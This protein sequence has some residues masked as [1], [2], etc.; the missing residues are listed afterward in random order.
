MGGAGGEGGPPLNTNTLNTAAA[1]GG[2][3]STTMIPSP[4][5]FFQSSP[6]VTEDPFSQLASPQS[7]S[8]SAPSGPSS[9]PETLQTPAPSNLPSLSP[10]LPQPPPASAQLFMPPPQAGPLPSSAIKRPTYAP[11]PYLNLPGG[12]PAPAPTP[13]SSLNIAGLPP[14]PEPKTIQDRSPFPAPSPAVIPPSQSA[15]SL[16]MAGSEGVTAHWFY[17]LQGEQEVWRPFSVEDST[18]LEASSSR[19]DSTK[20]IPVDGTRYDAYIEKR[21]KVPVYWPGRELP[22]RRCSWFHRRDPEGRWVPY[23]ESQAEQLE[24]EY[25]A[26]RQSGRWQCK[27][28]FDSGEWVMLHSPGV[29]MHFPTSS[30]SHGALDDW[31]QVQ[32]QSDPAS[33]PQVVH[34]GLEGLPDIPDGESLEVDHVFFVVHGIGAA[35]DM[36]FRPLEEVVDGFRDITADMSE[37]HFAGAHLASRANRVEF[38]PVHWHE[39]LHGEDAGTDKRIQPLTLRSIPKLRSFVNDTLLD[40]LFYTSPIYCQTI[41]DTVCGEINR[42]YKLFCSRN[43][44]LP[45]LLLTIAIILNFLCRIC[46]SVL[47]GWSQSGLSHPV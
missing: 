7:V 36:K 37:K 8:L 13:A 40:V 3:A 1:A 14:L 6:A 5:S 21:T 19:G 2:P 22:I 28:V 10:S 39:R 16:P 42:I 44:G 45:Y 17:R 18:V 4:M 9:P 24:R 25:Q 30:T 33:K 26:A 43:P 34:R 20:P 47:C 46:W 35:C 11:T 41:L 32:P 23:E 12:Q 38:L 31:G 27:V 29:M 15:A